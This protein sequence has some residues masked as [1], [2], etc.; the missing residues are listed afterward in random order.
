VFRELKTTAQLA[1]VL[2]TDNPA[3]SMQNLQ[4]FEEFYE[5]HGMPNEAEKDVL[6]VFGRVSIPDLE[7]WCKQMKPFCYNVHKLC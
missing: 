6:S 2:P 7:C 3:I 4:L 5:E 1:G